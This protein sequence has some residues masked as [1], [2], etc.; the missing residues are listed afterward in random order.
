MSDTLKNDHS[1]ECFVIYNILILLKTILIT[2]EFVPLHP[3]KK[4]GYS[5]TIKRF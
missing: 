2:A 3:Q 5:L 1:S 4:G